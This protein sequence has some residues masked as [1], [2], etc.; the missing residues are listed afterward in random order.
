MNNITSATLY[1]GT[2]FDQQYPGSLE[3]ARIV[4]QEVFSIARVQS[5]I[6]VGCGVAPWLR[7]ALDLGVRQAVG[8]DGDYV[9]PTRLLV[10]PDQFRSCNLETDNLVQAVSD[11][12]RFDVAMCLEVAEHL[13]GNRA[14]SF[15]S[16]ICKLSD[17][18]LF[19]AAVPGQGGTNHINEQWP[20]YWADFFNQ[21]GFACFDILRSRLWNRAECEWWY[22]QN[23]VLFARRDSNAYTALEFL[24]P[25]V[26]H[27]LPLV[28]P[29]MLEQ[30][31]AECERLRQENAAMRASRSWRVTAP[32]RRMASFLR[33]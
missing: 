27:P 17:L 1:S 16:E 12:G 33:P 31:R 23:V 21:S 13:S 20:Y 19:S 25:E 11:Y 8:L 18:V 28:H 30:L 7:A 4:L 26:T 32:L 15:V 3:S 5:V 24:G 29:R 14:P 10:A 2:F 6:D 9:D 22:L